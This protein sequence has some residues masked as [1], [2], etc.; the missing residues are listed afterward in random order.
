MIHHTGNFNKLGLFLSMILF[1]GGLLAATITGTDRV[2]TYQDQS[3]WKLQ[4]DGEDYF[5]KGMVWGYTPIGENYSYNLW[6]SS[7]DQ[8][9]KVLDYD[10]DLM[11]KAGVNTIRQFGGIPP[12]W[13]TY[14]YE[15]HGIRTIVNHLMGRYGFNVNGVW[16]PRTNYQDPA[17]REAL[18]QDFLAMVNEYKDTP[19]VLMFALGNENNYGLEWSSFEIENL[20]AGERQQEKAKYLYTLYDETMAAA[21]AVDPQHPYLIV[22]GDIQ[23]LDLVSRYCPHLDVLGVNSYRGVSFTDMW[24]RVHAELGKPVLLTEFGS[25]AYNAVQDHEDQE[26]QAGILRGNW[27]EI[28]NKSYGKAEEG[29]ALGG[30]VFEWRDEWWKYKQTENLD[31]HDRNASWSNGGYSFDYVPGVNN[32]NEEWFGICRLGQPNQDG[33]SEAVPRMSYDIL[34]KIWETNPYAVDKTEMNQRLA[35]V[36]MDFYSLFSSMRALKSE[37]RESDIL[38]L[39]GG[40]LRGDMAFYGK[41]KNVED[42][43]KNGVD[44]TNGEMLFLD[45]GFQ[46]TAKIDGY[47]SLNILGNVANLPMEQYYGKRGESYVAVTSETDDAGLT[48][49]NTKSIADNERVE[50]YHF[51]AEYKGDDFDFTTFYHVPRYHWGYEGDFFGLLH[52]TTDMDGMDIWN[53]KAPYGVEFAGKGALDGLKVVTGPEVYWGANPKAIVKYNFGSDRFKYTFVHSEDFSEAEA[54]ATDTEATVRATRQTAFSLKTTV[55]PGTTLELG[56]LVAGSEK[57]DD[58]YDYMD[59]GKIYTDKIEFKD[60]Q[61]AKAKLS[62]LMGSALFDASVTYAGLVADAG[63]ALE[64]RDTTLPHSDLGNKIEYEAGLLLP[65]GNVWLLP[66]ALYRTNLLNAMPNNPASMDGTEFNPGSSTRNR[67]D[68]PFAVLDNREAKAGEFF[69]TYDPTPATSFY[70]WDRDRKEDARCAFSVGGNYIKY[71]TVTDAYLFYYE[72]GKTNA[73]FG[74]GLPKADV[75]EANGKFILNP[76]PG[77]RIISNVSGGQEQSTGKPDGGK[78]RFFTVDS[79]FVINK[80]HTVSAYFKKDA[81]GPYDWYRQFNITYPH[82]FML[83]YSIMLDNLLLEKVSSR[84]GCKALYRT[85]R[86]GSPVNEGDGVNSDYEFQAGIYYRIDF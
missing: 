63:E 8:I 75:W 18:K 48:V 85:L 4:V 26:G 61:A 43:G 57:I 47:L 66:R 67:D 62:F 51:L 81:W 20:P 68:D 11:K 50:I 73:S 82:Q 36:D 72:E 22:N 55:I 13:I 52:E 12:R 53:A 77:L 46:P 76:N 42:E 39:S 28:Y 5:V 7:D 16:Y 49:N 33:V 29:N 1:T 80:R 40:S 23:Y 27:T 45:F 3:G 70:D 17:T 58:K 60:T 59:G 10:C 32:M 64:E 37:K 34:R 78:A 25:D 9:R 6:A 44:Y 31:V 30:C 14:I 79:K 2:T 15:K 35:A 69:I 21:K 19:G 86:A 56:Y 71:T 84:I 74:E 41:S 24:H 54:S 38:R 65:I 83:D